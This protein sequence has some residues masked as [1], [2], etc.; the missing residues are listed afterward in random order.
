MVGLGQAETTDGLPGGQFGKPLLFLFLAAVGV[1]RVHHEPTL[2]A[3]HRPHTRVTGL[4]LLH[5]Q[6]VGPVADPGKPVPL[7]FGAEKAELSHFG[8]DL[9]RKGSLDVV[10]A[11]VRAHF[12]LEEVTGGVPDHPFFRGEFGLQIE[13]I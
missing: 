11:D 6:T 13:V 4:E 12:L 1:N 7:E 5:Q 2:D 9:C 10:L 3:P 8:D